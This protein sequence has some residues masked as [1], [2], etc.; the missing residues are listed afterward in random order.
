MPA[1]L[2]WIREYAVPL[3]ILLQKL[4]KHKE[5]G[6]ELTLPQSRRMASLSPVFPMAAV[7]LD[8]LEGA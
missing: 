8:A 4:I 2:R 7:G 6:R 1:T 3:I 5:V